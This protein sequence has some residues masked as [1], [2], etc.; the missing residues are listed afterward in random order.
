MKKIIKFA[1]F[2][3]TDGTRRSLSHKVSGRFR[4]WKHYLQRPKCH[5]RWPNG[6]L[7]L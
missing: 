3:M 2:Q 1:T 4:V 6:T 7:I 5:Y